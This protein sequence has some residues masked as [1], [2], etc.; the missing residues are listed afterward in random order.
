MTMPMS[1]DTKTATLT[2][3]DGKTKTK[4]PVRLV[5]VSQISVDSE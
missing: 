5:N 2:S 4:V 3:A 1:D